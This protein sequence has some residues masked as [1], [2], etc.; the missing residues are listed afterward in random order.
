MATVEIK[1]KRTGEIKSISKSE[2]GI[3][4]IRDNWDCITSERDIDGDSKPDDNWTKNDIMKYL[5]DKGVEYKTSEKKADLLAK[6]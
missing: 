2:L 5:S 6:C 4:H 3:L 1:H